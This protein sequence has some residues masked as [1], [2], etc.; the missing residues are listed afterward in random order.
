[1]PEGPSIA[2]LREEVASFARRKVL[3]VKGDSKLDLLRFILNRTSGSPATGTPFR[4]R[5]VKGERG[6]VELGCKAFSQIE[7]FVLVDTE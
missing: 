3:R 7:F 1:M 4:R 2:I 6:K 5:H